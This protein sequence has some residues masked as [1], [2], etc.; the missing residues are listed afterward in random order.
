MK[1]KERFPSSSK[2]FAGLKMT[3]RRCFRSPIVLGLGQAHRQD[4]QP[5]K[6]TEANVF[7]EMDATVWAD[8]RVEEARSEG[9][10]LRF[11]LNSQVGGPCILG[12]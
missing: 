7:C 4:L 10:A 8:R 2:I 3:F 6:Q 1:T 11:K 12:S 9:M 5:W